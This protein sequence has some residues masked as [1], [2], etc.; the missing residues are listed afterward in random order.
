M[1]VSRG[2]F[3]RASTAR[4]PLSLA[5][6]TLVVL[7]AVLGTLQYR[8]V[9]QVGEAERA[10]ELAD[11]QRRLQQP[12][13]GPGRAEHGGFRGPFGFVA[14]EA[15][16]LVVPMFAEPPP[17]EGGARPPGRPKSSGS[18]VIVLDRA[19]IQRE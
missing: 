17:P 1:L 9:G 16:A 15:P 5:V 2:M 3:D 7:L 12:E 14:D 11:L 8:W 10:R 4:V 6:V 18:T 19:Y 13:G